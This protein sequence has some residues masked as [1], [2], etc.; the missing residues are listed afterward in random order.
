MQGG[1]VLLPDGLAERPRG[2]GRPVLL[3]EGTAERGRGAG[4]PV[5]LPGGTGERPRGAGRGG[6]APGRAR[7]EWSGCREL[8]RALTIWSVSIIPIFATNPH[9]KERVSSI[10]ARKRYQPFS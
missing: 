7:R 10:F 8:R 4:R 3:P 5:L 6:F 9:S 1:V 2:A